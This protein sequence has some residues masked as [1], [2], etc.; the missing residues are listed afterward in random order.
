MV[1]LT[2]YIRR[3]IKSRPPAVQMGH[4]R[5][6]KPSSAKWQLTRRPAGRLMVGLT[7]S[8]TT[9]KSVFVSDSVFSPFVGK[10]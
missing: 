6:A 8:D 7:E 1:I 5:E 10:L 9:V 4:T 3:A 2:S